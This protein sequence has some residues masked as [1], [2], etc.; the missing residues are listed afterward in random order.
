MH[1]M[2]GLAHV[3]EWAGPD[4]AYN[5]DFIPD[6]KLDWKP[7]PDS[8]SAMACAAEAAYFMRGMIG[9]LQT[10][11]MKMETPENLTRA[12]LQE[13][14]RKGSAEYAAALRTIPLEKLGDQVETP[15]G[16]FPLAQLAGF[17]VID[18]I[19]HRGQVCYIQTMLG[20]T[21]SHFLMS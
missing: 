9:M 18:I 5:L 11:E 7:A 14:L 13:E 6:D 19:H 4:L 20:D 16:T 17:P 1:P 2:D 21:E 12:M 3:L 8:K 15:F 10:G